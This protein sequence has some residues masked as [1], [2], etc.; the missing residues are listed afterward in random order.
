NGVAKYTTTGSIEWIKLYLPGDNFQPANIS[1]V[2][3]DNSGFIY[4]TGS[5]S[6]FDFPTRSSYDSLFVRKMSD[7]TLQSD[8]SDSVFSIVKSIPISQDVNMGTVLAG[9]FKDNVVSTFIRNAGSYPFEVESIDFGGTASNSFSIVSGIPP[10]TVPPRVSMPVEFRFIPYDSGLYKST[11]NILIQDSVL[12]QNIQGVGVRPLLKLETPF[13]DF[14]TVDVGKVRDSVALTITNISTFA[15]TITNTH[16]AGP[17]IADFSAVTGAGAF[18]LAPNASRTM[19]L[20]FAPSEGGRTSGRILFDYNGPGSP[21]VMQLFGTGIR[22]KPEISAP[23]NMEFGRLTCQESFDTTITISNSGEHVLDVSNAVI[24]GVNGSDFSL[25]SSLAGATIEP[26]SFLTI[27]LRFRPSALGSS[28]ADL[29]IHSDADPDSVFHISLEGAK[30]SAGFVADSIL[31]L[32]DVCPNATV[33]TAF[34][35]AN[36]GTIPIGIGLQPPAELTAQADTLVIPVAGKTGIRLHFDGRTSEGTF[37]DSLVISDSICNR[38]HV[39][40][41]RGNIRIPHPVIT[42]IGS[43][44]ICDSGSVILRAPLG[45]VSYLWQPNSEQTD[46]IVARSTGLY[47][48]TVTDSHGCIGTSLPISIRPDTITNIAMQP[49]GLVSICLGDTV[50][51]SVPEAFTEWS[52]N[53]GTASRTRKVS[54][55]GVFWVSGKTEEGCFG[56]SQV[57]TVIRASRSIHVSVEPIQASVGD[58]ATLSVYLNDPLFECDNS[59]VQVS[60][61]MNTDILTPIAIETDGTLLAGASAGTILIRGNRGVTCSLQPIQGLAA[62]LDLT[63]PLFKLRTQVYLSNTLVTPIIIDSFRYASKENKLAI[64]T[65]PDTVFSVRTQCGDQAIST[66][67]GSDKLPDMTVIPNPLSGRTT[68]PIRYELPVASGVHID[69]VSETGLILKTLHHSTAEKA[70]SHEIMGDL[71]GISSGRYFLVFSTTT[72]FVKPVS[73]IYCK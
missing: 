15:V 5:W 27:S 56:R 65:L 13:I 9:T 57:T 53:D 1:D 6:G 72:G 30:D 67:I 54:T 51:L 39:V 41:I 42:V 7:E 4:T 26:D 36:T 63:V 22:R 55:P 43:P 34:V 62:P 8:I 28:I 52:W 37:D 17:N 29:E 20:R 35:L 14:D 40:R 33:D 21:A 69:L 24:T 45:F 25:T 23:S 18:T 44:T 70:G 11:I 46:S 71:D 59:T 50:E 47:S 60:F 38:N 31:D 64:C 3:V 68:I 49:G 2:A 73:L 32:G 66:F 48:V 58:M 12:I 19:T 61:T 16:E 10:F